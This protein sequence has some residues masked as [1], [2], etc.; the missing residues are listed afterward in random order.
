MYLTPFLSTL[1][2]RM[3]LAKQGSKTGVRVHFP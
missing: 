1:A 2:I 3:Y